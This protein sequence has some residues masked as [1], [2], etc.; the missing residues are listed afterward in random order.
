M[1]TASGFTW[2]RL[3]LIFAVGAALAQTVPVPPQSGNLSAKPSSRYTRAPAPTP[4][5]P[6]GNLP[7]ANHA[8]A[9]PAPTVLADPPVSMRVIV[10]LRPA[11]AQS[12]ALALPT[13]TGKVNMASANAGDPNLAALLAKHGVRAIAPLSLGHVRAR[14]QLGT[15]GAKTRPTTRQRFPARAARA[16]VNETPPD[17]A[18]TYVFE[19]AARPAAEVAATVRS[20]Q[21]DASVSYAEVDRVVKASYVPND[22]SYATSGSWGQP[23]D[24]LYGLKKIGT[25]QAWDTT[26]GQ[27]VIV[28]VVDTGIDYNHPDISNNVWTNS[29]EIAGDGIDE[30]QNGFV[31]DVRGWDFVGHDYTQPVEDNDPYDGYFHGTHVAGTIA[32]TGDNNL[33]VVGV[34][35][36][37]KVMA[38]KALDDNGYGLE[39]GL[40][41]A[42]IYATD[43]GADVI[44]ASW[45]AE[46]TSQTIADAINYAHA[47]GVVVVAA[48]GNDSKSASTFF[49]ANVPNAIAVSSL[50][51]YDNLSSFSNF[52]SKVELAAP[53]EDIL[54]LQAGTGGY[55]QASGTSMA[56]PHVSGVAALIIAQHPT[57]SNEQVRQALRI[58]ATDLGEVG[59]DSSFGYGR[60]SAAD[61]VLVNQALEAQIQSP[62]SGGAPVMGPT[63]LTGSAGGPGFDHY[64]ISFFPASGT[65]PFSITRISNSPVTNGDLGTFDPSALTDGLYTVK[66]QVY[67]TD[68][69]S[70][71]DQIQIQVRYLE[72]TSPVA[73]AVP[74]LTQEVK[75]GTALAIT[76]TA[77]GPSF[78]HY[79]LEW[80]RG[81]GA[82]TGWSTSGV[83]LAGNGL[84]PV[85]SGVLG[86][87]TPAALLKG[88]FTIRLTVTNAAFSSSTTTAVYAEP[89]LI[90][91][92]WPQFVG[93][94]DFG[95]SPLPMRQADGTTR[96]VIC[97]FHNS[98]GTSLYSYGL[99]G[100]LLTAPLDFGGQRQPCVGN[101]DGLPGDEVVLADG[102]S[103]KVFSSSLAPVRT[104]T[105]AQPR[106]FWVDQTILADLDNDGVPEIIAPAR[107]TQSPTGTTYRESG[108]L[109]VYRADGSLYSN[110]YPL[111][112]TS[113]LTPTGSYD[114]FYG[115]QVVA[116]DLDG[117]GKK[118]IVMAIEANDYSGYTLQAI[119]ADG[120]PHAGWSNLSI[121]GSY[122]ESLSAADLD[123]NGTTEL[124]IAESSRDGSTHQVR[125]VN[126]TGQVRAGWPVAMQSNAVLSIGDLDH[127]QLH[128]IV[129]AADRTLTILRADG[130]LWNQ[131]WTIGDGPNGRSNTTPLIADIDGD[132]LPDILIATSTFGYN[133]GLYHVTSLV[134]YHP[135]GSVQ[136][137]WPLFGL[138]GRQP[139]VGLPLVGDFNGDGRTDLVV[140]TALIDGG[141]LSGYLN[142]AALTW[143]TTGTTFN[144]AGSEW[145]SNLHDPLA[146]RSVNFAPQ[147]TTSPLGKSVAVGAAVAFNAAASGGPIP[148]FQWQRNGVNLAGA[149]T[150]AMA[151]VNVQPGNAGT[152]TVVA[153]NLLG[154][155]TS[156]GAVLTVN[157]A[158]PAPAIT[159]Q[160]VSQGVVLG[161]SVTFV[162]A[163]SGTPT[164]TLRWQKN[165]SNITGATNS[166]LTL[167]NVKLSDVATYR[168]V[169]TNALGSATSNG[170]VLTIITP[171]AITTQPTSRTVLVG[172][173]VTFTAAASGA[174]VPTFQW[175]RNGANLVGAT[176]A[177]LTLTNVQPADAA[178]YRVVATNSGGSAFSRAAV[179]TVNAPPAIT[180]QPASQ[181]AIT[182]TTVTFTAAA[183]GSPAPTFRWQKNGSNL[184]GA[185]LSSLTLTNVKLSDA[186]TYRVVASNSAGT[187]T[188]N[189]AVLTV[190]APPVITTQPASKTVSIGASATFTAAASGTPAPTFQWQKNGANLAGATKSSLTLTN[191]QM[192]DTATYRVVATNSAG[193]ATSNGAV[194]TVNGRPLI[195]TQ[196]A[197][198]VVPIGGTVTFTVG[199]LGSPMPTF[200]WQKNG[201]NISGATR[202]SLTLTNV[203][204]AAAGTYR[205]ILT[206][207]YGSVTSNGAGLSFAPAAAPV[208]TMQSGDQ[209]V[210]SG[211]SVTFT[212]VVT[213]SPT[214]SLQW[215]RF[216][217]N[218]A[219]ATNASL[220]LTN[221]QQ[222]DRGTYQLIAINYLGTAVSEPAVLTVD[223]YDSPVAFWMQPASQTVAIGGSVTFTAEASGFPAATYQ[224]QKDSADIVGA[225][226][227]SLT[228]DNVQPADAGSYWVIAANRISGAISDAAVLT[229]RAS[230]TA[231]GDLNGDGKSDVTLT[232]TVTGERVFWLMNGTSITRSSSLGVTPLYMSFSALRDFNNDGKA[233]IFVTFT[234]TGDRSLWLMDG[235]NLAAVTWPYS[236]Q[237]SP[238]WVVNGTG[239]F[240]DD[241]QPDVLFS[242]IVTGE[243]QLW[244]MNGTAISSIVSLG[245]YSTD[246][247]FDYAADFTKDGRTDILASNTV[248]GERAIWIMDR[249]VVYYVSTLGVW[250]P[251]LTVAGVGDFDGD[252]RT[253]ILLFDAVAGGGTIW[254]MNGVSIN[255]AGSLPVLAS[256]WRF[257]LVGDFDGD[258]KDDILLTDTAT[259]ERVVWLMNGYA[260]KASASLGIL[261]TDW[262][263][264][265]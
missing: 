239:D 77:T 110:H 46:G 215:V 191:I 6:G 130:T 1:K 21:A 159:T 256:T 55:L 56:A 160:P 141:G 58:S 66:L 249:T 142:Y 19:L 76:G 102:P 107:D 190:S 2:L 170:A 108:A 12:L 88:D 188:S 168:V 80:A 118:E 180:T 22:P 82:T 63:A 154:S 67:A 167:A 57:W 49:P 20:L 245:V 71:S 182:G 211:S 87:W 244:L 60:V 27:G 94:T 104:I 3:G 73:P 64:V 221:V 117:D 179:L 147:I 139:Y 25:T 86:T 146:S 165:G 74:S 237:L 251:G 125:V 129:V 75:S 152:Y 229:V 173:S 48:A 11:L 101:L 155:A 192:T 231:R 133:P 105:P 13:T 218:I 61:A 265:N 208:I 262:L 172:A 163:A 144:A 228:L 131:P 51:P 203:Q 8:P 138:A 78:Q 259:G 161:G 151:L 136:K 132:G 162:A 91:S 169:A 263:I 143:L 123:H 260:V 175:Q 53:G 194:L 98:G 33:G 209:L 4:G 28:A 39:S 45:G 264:R 148:T 31:D 109:Y 44:N 99:D 112:I 187:A 158:D 50:D 92:A 252:G 248:T 42:I 90:S 157:V 184:S 68:G 127:D 9:T 34:A 62:A 29:G 243:R 126:S 238:D 214:P 111:T 226:N 15:P 149:T 83:T 222:A 257:S 52:G 95:L 210:P 250:P 171:P 177:T 230:L 174:P 84:A 59:R 43:N 79:L 166:S 207:S 246:W 206:N 10:K 16:P 213:G 115:V 199:Y 254:L 23:Y 114:G 37:A 122:F 242:N 233:D 234:D 255:T 183:S 7:A 261:S 35:W 145:T 153:T 124:V 247:V 181:A 227:A 119:N 96:M 205:V 225:T 24:D 5:K 120:T 81:A 65:G 113:P 85:T 41:K 217:T 14:Q 30:D 220:T 176:N 121:L 186:A 26:Q 32:A 54:S 197:S 193:S 178:T 97:G 18:S 240:N 216:G 135:N 17:L 140:Q 38:L 72:I 189:G 106:V 89:A 212:T 224:W 40:A 100:S 36:K 150:P 241:G 195:T 116:V 156:I 253:D 198:Q 185:T 219:G 93:P 223:A 69:S 232:N 70:Y 201:D 202:S 196:P 134:W 164:P 258:G 137:S 236:G 47:H 204:A 128:E 235:T 200:R 103:L